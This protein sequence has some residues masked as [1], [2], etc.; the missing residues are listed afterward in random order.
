LEVIRYR[1]RVTKLDDVSLF[2][3][4]SRDKGIKLEVVVERVCLCS[5]CRASWWAEAGEPT[6]HRCPVTGR[7]ERFE[8]PA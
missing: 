6:E 7:L 1:Q 8:V 2:E 3:P 4:L 5:R